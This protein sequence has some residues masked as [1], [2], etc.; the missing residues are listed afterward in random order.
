MSLSELYQ[1]ERAL[2]GTTTPDFPFIVK[3]I[4]AKQKLSVQLHEADETEGKSKHEAWV[5]LSAAPGSQ[6]ILDSECRTSNELLN[7]IED[8]SFLEKLNNVSVHA[9]DVYSIPA[10][11]IHAIGEG[12]IIYEIQQPSD[13]TY[14]LH[15]FIG[16]RDIHLEEGANAFIPD[17]FCSKIIPDDIDENTLLLIMNDYFIVE[18]IN[19]CKLQSQFASDRFLVYTAL[20]DGSIEGED[21][22]YKYKT[23]ESF[24]IPA[25]H[26]EFALNGGELIKS[27]VPTKFVI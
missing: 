10:G 15:D 25:G 22:V 26:G 2:F 14:R 18:K 11:A 27:Y 1:K 3:L 21:C 8:N 19:A 7:A 20:G 4:D 5:I 9:G 13:L 17:A 24:M 23:G 12:I 16:G 6:I